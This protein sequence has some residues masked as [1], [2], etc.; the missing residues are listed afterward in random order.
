MV[1]KQET[2]VN[3]VV[4]LPTPLSE[5][6]I[7]N[8]QR[9]VEEAK[10]IKREFCD[11]SLEFV[12]EHSLNCMKQFGF[13]MDGRRVQTQDV[14]MLEQAIGALMYRYYG[15]EHPLHEVNDNVIKI[16]GEEDE[17]ISDDNS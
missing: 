11:E 2:P 1:P 3:N 12:M 15:L 6:Q 14:V 13:L 10:E 17:E 4:S 16:A 7:Y 5:S 8:A 9:C